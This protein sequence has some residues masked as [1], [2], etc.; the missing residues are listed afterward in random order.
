MAQTCNHDGYQSGQGRYDAAEQKLRYVIVC[1]ACDAELREVLVQ[2]YVP[3][4]DP[5]GND[6]YLAA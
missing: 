5:H 1:D 6:A 2:P 4:Y 3:G